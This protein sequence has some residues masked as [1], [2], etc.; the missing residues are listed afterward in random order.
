MFSQ[1]PQTHSYHNIVASEFTEPSGPYEVLESAERI[2]FPWIAWD[3]MSQTMSQEQVINP[4][5][6]PTNT[7][8]RLAFPESGRRHFSV[9]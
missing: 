1:G 6:H 8:Y 7:F 3:E 5:K 4:P 9:E 2:G